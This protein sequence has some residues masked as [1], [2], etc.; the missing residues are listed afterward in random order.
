M[1]LTPKE[2]L[3]RLFMEGIPPDQVLNR[4]KKA[5]LF[6]HDVAEHNSSSQE[7]V[8]VGQVDATTELKLQQSAA[9]YVGTV[10]TMQTTLGCFLICE[11]HNNQLVLADVRVHFDEDIVDKSHLTEILIEG[12]GIGT[13][14]TCI[15]ELILTPSARITY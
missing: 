4:L 9:R 11:N 13:L 8:S 7:R 12:K 2:I 1:F 10:Y 15:Q 5:V 14:T 6:T 3:Q